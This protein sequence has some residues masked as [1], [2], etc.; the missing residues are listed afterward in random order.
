MKKKRKIFCHELV[1]KFIICVRKEWKAKIS[2]WKTYFIN[3]HK[4]NFLCECVFV[5]KLHIHYLKIFDVYI[6]WWKSMRNVIYTYRAIL[7]KNYNF[8]S[9][10]VIA[11]CIPYQLNN[12]Y[13][14]FIQIWLR[15]RPKFDKLNW[16]MNLTVNTIEGHRIS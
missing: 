6:K 7:I 12:I 3:D 13:T 16:C 2:S 14:Q 5:W 8:H 1:L 15:Y 9:V 4:I 10:G 11:F